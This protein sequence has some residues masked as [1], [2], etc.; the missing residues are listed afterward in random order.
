M[1]NLIKGYITSILGLLGVIAIFLHGSGFFEFP[2]PDFL[3]KQSEITI[4]LIVCAALFI[5]PYSKIES[6]IESLMTWVI[7]KFKK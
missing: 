3:D 2:N 4:A 1:Q 5:L 7:E 6:I